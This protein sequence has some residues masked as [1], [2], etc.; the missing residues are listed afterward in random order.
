MKVGIKPATVKK[1]IKL[2][3]QGMLN[4]AHSPIRVMAAIQ[5]GVQSP[6]IMT[7]ESSPLMSDT[8]SSSRFTSP[9]S[10]QWS[11]VQ[12][13]S[14]DVNAPYTSTNTNVADTPSS[15]MLSSPQATEVAHGFTVPNIQLANQLKDVGITISHTMTNEPAIEV[16]H[17]QKSL[18][19]C[20]QL[21]WN[22]AACA[23]LQE[24]ASPI[25]GDTSTPQKLHNS[26]INLTNPQYQTDNQLYTDIQTSQ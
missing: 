19:Q 7:G 8:I 9:L 25:L 16:K 3:K 15:S 14:S 6:N 4:V 23:K 2:K 18:L 20:T 21:N 26:I 13:T 11:G 22:S 1:Y 24:F 5:Q 12:S 17:L 10:S